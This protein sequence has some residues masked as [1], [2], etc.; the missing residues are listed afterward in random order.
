MCCVFTVLIFLGPRVA[1]I[2]WWLIQP[3]RWSTAFG[4]A[5][6]PILGII[7]APWTTLMFV[8][9]NHPVL[10][11]SFLGWLFIALGI[12]A[13]ISMHGGGA[14]F[15]RDSVPGM[16]SSGTMEAAAP[17]APAEPADPTESA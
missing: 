8:A 16:S 6:W 9:V 1:D 11:I 3:A 4:S 12:F 14:Y 5:I 2:T 10:G 13:D 7:F 15:N 17:A